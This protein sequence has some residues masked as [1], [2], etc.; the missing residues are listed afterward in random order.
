MTVGF[1]RY[2]TEPLELVIEK[3][4]VEKPLEDYLKIAV[5][6]D[7]NTTDGSCHIDLL[8][9]QDAPEVDVENS[10]INI[11][12]TQKQSAQFFAASAKVEVNILYVDQERSASCE[13]VVNVFRNL[14]DKEL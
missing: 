2:E 5:S 3:E 8:Y 14:Y 9:D 11:H 6:F 1:H 7:Q 12:F 4:G 13:G 10:T